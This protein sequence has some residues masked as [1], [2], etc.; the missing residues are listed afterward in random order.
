MNPK[1]G[2]SSNYS[3]LPLAE[4]IV[5]NDTPIEL[6]SLPPPLTI[7]NETS[8]VSVPEMEGRIVFRGESLFETRATITPKGEYLLMFPTNSKSYPKGR[9]HYGRAESKTNDLVSFRSNDR[10]ETWTGP[11]V[12]FDIDYNQH[13]FIPLIP[14]GSN[15]LYSFG[16]QP[17]WGQYTRDFGLQENA[18]IGY[19]YSDDDGHNWSEVRLI[20]PTN[21]PEFTGMS[22]MRMCE[23]EAGTWL[24]GTHEGDWS[25]K[26]LITRQYLLRSTDQGK[27]WQLLPDRR[28][29][30]WHVLSHG[31]MDEGRPINTGTGE[32]LMMIRTPEGRLWQTWSKDD[33]LSWSDPQPSTLIHPDAPPMLF[34]LSTGE[35]AAFHH[36]RFHDHN[37]S[38]LD[39]SKEDVMADRSEIWVSFSSDGGHSWGPPRFVFCNAAIH[40]LESPFRNHQC[41]YIDAFIDSR[42]SERISSGA[43]LNIFVPHRWQQALHLQIAES[44]L[45]KLP[46]KE[47]LQL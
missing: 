43:I 22:V 27:S 31:R 6:D 4:K 24:L 26:P 45:K 25:Y 20:R 47:E 32:T 39:G 3:P 30:G 33:G 44:D 23:T 10:G 37:Y 8:L 12:A 19:R 29:G 38:G 14:R 40:D 36:N 34:P 35:L 11:K 16:T 21:D 18:P 28:H 7:N 41:S 42:P 15:R 17:M 1:K 5:I 2:T 13:G 9:C 46:L